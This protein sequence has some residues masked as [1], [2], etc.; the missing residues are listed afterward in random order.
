MR[1]TPCISV[2]NG[3]INSVNNS[4]NYRRKYPYPNRFG[5]SVASTKPA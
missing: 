3:V 2:I 1:E 4:I 5:R